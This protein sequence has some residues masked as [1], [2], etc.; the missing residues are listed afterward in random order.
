MNDDE[1]MK[2]LLPVMA[3]IIIYL[4]ALAWVANYKPEQKPVIIYTKPS[5]IYEVPGK[6]L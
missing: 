3:S 1:D 6:D 2:L 4:A 5:M